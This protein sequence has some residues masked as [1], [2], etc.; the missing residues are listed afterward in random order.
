MLLKETSQKARCATAH[1]GL[2]QWGEQP[3]RVQPIEVVVCRPTQGWELAEA[4]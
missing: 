1:G 3:C 4:D 2:I